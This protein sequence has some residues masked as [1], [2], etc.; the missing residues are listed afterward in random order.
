MTIDTSAVGIII[1]VLVALMGLA[2][3]YGILTQKVLTMK[4]RQD[5]LRED[6]KAY[7]VENKSEHKA[8]GDKLDT[9]LLNGRRNG[10]TE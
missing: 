5:T 6:F 7:L 1:T 2:Y 10:K 8:I 4:V 3:G 9:L